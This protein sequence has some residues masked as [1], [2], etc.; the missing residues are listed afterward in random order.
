MLHFNWALEFGR[1]GPSSQLREEID[2]AY[3]HQDS[4]SEQGRDNMEEDFQVLSDSR[5][6][7][8]EGE[9]LEH[10][11]LEEMAEAEFDDSYV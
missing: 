5:L 9:G 2:Q 4:S 1:S 3:H 11:A 6:E 8:G 10:E 7:E